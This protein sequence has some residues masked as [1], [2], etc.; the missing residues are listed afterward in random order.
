MQ[1]QDSRELTYVLEGGKEYR[2]Q[3]FGRVFLGETHLCRLWGLQD[4]GGHDRGNVD[5]PLI[6][7]G[8]TTMVCWFV[9]PRK[10]CARIALSIVLVAATVQTLD[11]AVSTVGRPYMQSVSIA[12]EYC[13]QM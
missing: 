10:S 6:T 5:Q 11:P 8:R 13:E 9:H 4:V 12:I 7:W 2:S 1:P 3:L